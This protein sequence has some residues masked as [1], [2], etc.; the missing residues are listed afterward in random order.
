MSDDTETFDM[1]FWIPKL[2]FLAITIVTVM[3]L[4]YVFYYQDVKS[5]VAE[6]Q[7]LIEGTYSSW[8]AYQDP[9]TKRV[10]PGIVDAEKFKSDEFSLE[11]A[12][13]NIAMKVNLVIDGQ[14]FTRYYVSGS[15]STD[16]NFN[17]FE[18]LIDYPER[19]SKLTQ[20]PMTKQVSVMEGDE[21]KKGN[22]EFFV[23]IQK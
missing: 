21:L 5:D 12:R 1:I 19:I 10:Y 14:T 15:E 3:M 17:S 18:A 16:Q 8:F 13:N 22:L 4:I 9:L 6:M 7:I 23:L 11:T 20:Y 2:I